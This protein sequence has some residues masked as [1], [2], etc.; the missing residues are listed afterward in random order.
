[1]QFISAYNSGRL[2]DI[3][4]CTEEGQSMAKTSLPPQNQRRDDAP[5]AGKSKS[6]P[7]SRLFWF[8]SRLLVVVVLLGILA[9]FAPQI[10]GGSGL[11]KSVL[12][13]AAP[14]LAPQIDATAVQLAWLSPIEIRGLVVRDPA[15]QPLVEVPLVRSHK[16]LLAIA[17]NSR[18]VGT[19]EITEPKANV[20]LRGDG[21]NAED[22]LAKLPKSSGKP[23][24][25]GFGLAISKATVAF[26][27]Q[28]AGRQWQ[29][30]SLSLDLNWP[31]GANEQKKGKLTAVVQ[32]VGA[33]T[34]PS[35][36][37]AA[38]FGWQPS[39]NDKAPL[40]A[41]QA[42]L[43]LQ[44]LPTELAQ[45]G[46][47]RFV[48]DI[49]PRGPLTLQAA[50]AWK[51]DGSLQV[52]INQ[53][54]TPGVSISAPRLLGTDTP[55]IAI[56]SGQGAVQIAGRQIDVRN[57]QLT[58]NLINVAANGVIQ[59]SQP[60]QSANLQLSGQINLVE[61]AR[62]L[63]ATLHLRPDT[64]LNSGA[65][66]FSL[67]SQPAGDGR[68]WQGSLKTHDL[69][70]YAA[71]RPIE[72]DQPLAIDFSVLQ[73]PAGPTIEQLVG[74]ASFLRLEGRG[75][76]TDGSIAA[77]T[78]L[79]QLMAEVERII[80]LGNTRLK[81]KLAANVRWKHDAAS[82]WNA[83]AE[84]D[85]Q[86]FEAVADGLAPWNEAKLH[87]AANLQGELADGSIRQI[88]AG[89]LT[90]ESGA[91]RLDAQLTQPV[92]SPSLGSAWP[93]KFTLRGDLATWQPR[94]QPIVPLAGWRLAGGIDANGNLR[95]STQETEFTQAAIQLNQ[96]KARGPNVFI[97]EPIIKVETAGAW[98]QP[99]A[100]LTLGST[101]L[102]AS[103]IALRADGA[104]VVMGKEPSLVGTI[105]FR[106]D[107]GRLS[108]WLGSPDQ[109]RTS[110][111][112][113]SIEES[114]IEMG[115]RG[116][117]LAASW[118]VNVDN[119][120]YLVAP[121]RPAGA[122]AALA[123]T[124]AAANA[125]QPV[126]QEPKVNFSGQ[127]TFD[128]ATSTLKVERTNLAASSGSVTAAGTL[129]KLT[130][131]PDID[132]SGEI[133]YDLAILTQ[134]I[135]SQ[136]QR[137]APRGAARLPYGLD[138]LQLAGKQKRPFMLK[139]PL[140]G[141]LTP[142]GTAAATA[143]TGT[144]S[145]FGVSEALTGEAS[146]GWQGAQ[147]VGLVAGP[148]DFRAKL[149]GGVV[150]VGPLDVPL[151]EGRLTSAP[152]IL[153]N[154]RVPQIAVA[155]GPL[156]E[157]VRISPEMCSLWLKYI[158]P[159]VADAA[160]AEGKLS[161]SLEGASVPLAAP[162]AGDVV[163]TLS[164]QSAQVGPGQTGLA[165]VGLARELYALIIGGGAAGANTNQDSALLTLPQQDVPFEVKNEVVSHRGLKIAIG[166]LAITTQG[167]VNLQTEEYNLL[168]SVPLP[169]NLFRGRE[170]LLASLKG[171]TLQLPIQ[172]N[173]NK[174]LDLGKLVADI[175]KQNAA[176][177]VQN[178]IGRQ[179]ERGM[180]GDGLLPGEIGQGL[181]RLFGPRQ[182]QPQQPQQPPPQ[183]PPP[184]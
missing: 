9:F 129:S 136:A 24:P 171:Q 168:A 91:D 15:G 100:T 181:N 74:T 128:P 159:Q 137:G 124:S 67:A 33:A 151:A 144:A 21:S 45:G 131:S 146:L 94:L 119:L 57:L 153:L 105:D 87:L 71:G 53:L 163:G 61:L 27:D 28:V 23:Q 31:A 69:R 59:A 111:L 172:G 19:F 149:A 121:A 36:Q 93:L 140:W 4:A 147:Y 135:Q 178:I 166:E 49:R 177:A 38:E 112:A 50:G 126:W 116:Q 47:R 164:I 103:A 20:V 98:N 132:L 123:S 155:R 82:G 97:D 22:L 65:A 52:L 108:G 167:T 96:L 79:D 183:N 90:V 2:F 41:G 102:Q 118:N 115:Y 1:V 92:S 78:D 122:T 34:T 42:K 156:L 55:T 127:G 161:L 175:V 44:G 70:G 54:T 99:K 84:A 66:D 104:R 39:T 7:R 141:N 139:G 109:P 11:W 8:G 10:I 30:D 157:N 56:A 3:I 143:S 113:G 180:R 51:D 35:G 72:F 75:S 138:T 63:P 88:N 76:L 184:R 148:A 12:A 170:G 120:A 142:A 48:G 179:L 89:S 130:S 182:P 162:L 6:R 14:Q 32:P 68:R 73:T 58:T 64:N 26:N 110:A 173:F 101:T 18:D 77:Q 60:A 85:V 80:D 134:E 62:Q 165:F 83:V 169:E 133:A 5:R 125:W 174:R 43:T 25:I 176:G 13:I 145:G 29:I 152:R 150:Q 106:G 114:R 95:F 40:G 17:L 107:I 154:D 37:L 86:N 160:H 46:L 81:G 117:T 16:T 158:A